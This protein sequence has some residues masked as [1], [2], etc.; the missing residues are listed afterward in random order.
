MNH[1][2]Q[3]TDSQNEPV[4]IIKTI[5]VTIMPLNE[6]IKKLAIAEDDHTYS[7]E[8]INIKNQMKL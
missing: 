2:Q 5:E 4:A 8:L 1:Y 7:C 6:I 3:L